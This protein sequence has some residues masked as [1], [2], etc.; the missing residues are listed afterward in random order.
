VTP[1]DRTDALPA[2]A[3]AVAV[4]M[5][6]LSVEHDRVVPMPVSVSDPNSDATDIDTDTFR[7]DHRLV[8]GVQGSGKCRHRQHRNEKKGKHYIL[9]DALIG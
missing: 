9:H 4:V 1:S 5:V 6:V 8:A 2:V 3:I 7:D